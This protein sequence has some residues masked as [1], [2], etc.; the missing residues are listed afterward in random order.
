MPPKTRQKE[1][2]KMPT[3]KIDVNI[4]V[5]A[6]LTLENTLFEAQKAASEAHPGDPNFQTRERT[7]LERVPGSTDKNSAGKT[8]FRNVELIR[9]AI[10]SLFDDSTTEGIAVVDRKP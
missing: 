7:I 1:T 10:H 3:N 9:H 5:D 8:R 4:P 6:L 2:R